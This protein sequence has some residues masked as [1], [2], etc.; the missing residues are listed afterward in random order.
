MGNTYSVYFDRRK[1]QFLSQP[2]DQLNREDALVKDAVDWDTFVHFIDSEKSSLLV[3]GN[4]PARMFRQF[5]TLFYNIEAA[6][7]LVTDPSGYWLFIFR[8]NRW[9]LPKGKTEK[10]E[11]AEKA[12]I[13]EVQEECGIDNLQ[14]VQSLPQTYH[15]YPYSEKQWALKKTHWYFMKTS[16]C[17][18]AEPQ[19]SEGIIRAEWMHPD[20]LSEVLSNTY[21]NIKELLTLCQ[22]LRKQG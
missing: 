13:R 11:P 6:G 10:N 15:V 3:A 8:K 19:V 17:C 21:G 14:I 9:D 1:I 12:A 22:Q 4:N 2:P 7:G 5:A 16:K 20:N 18:R